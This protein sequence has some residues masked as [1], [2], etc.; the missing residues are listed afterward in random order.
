MPNSGIMDKRKVRDEK[1]GESANKANVNRNILI[2][3]Y[4]GYATKEGMKISV[5]DEDDFPDLPVTPAKPPPSKKGKQDTTSNAME[6]NFV[7]APEFVSSLAQLINT[8]SD[9]LESLI[10]ENKTGIADLKKQI[11]NICEDVNAV[12]KRKKTTASCRVAVERGARE[13]LQRVF[14]S[15]HPSILAGFIEGRFYLD[16]VELLHLLVQVANAVVD[17]FILS[18]R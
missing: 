5:M 16:I 4:H 1:A 3:N 12:K 18:G 11:H 6:T 8:R 17:A 13:M 10:Q 2:D 14:S 7:D 15:N 9:K